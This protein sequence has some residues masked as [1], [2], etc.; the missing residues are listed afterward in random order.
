MTGEI[1]IHVVDV[2][3]GLPTAGMKVEI[4]KRGDK[5]AEGVLSS[6]GVLDILVSSTVNLATLYPKNFPF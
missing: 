2:T 5:I 4:F 3:W 1:S 6:Q